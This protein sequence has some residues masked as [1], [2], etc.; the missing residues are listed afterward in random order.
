MCKMKKEKASTLSALFSSAVNLSALSLPPEAAAVI[1]ACSPALQ[2]SMEIALSN[3]GASRM[4]DREKQ[5]VESTIRYA[6]S[7]ADRN[8][9]TGWSIK[10]KELEG[11]EVEAFIEIVYRAAAEDAQEMKEKAYASLIGNFAFQDRFDMGALSNLAIILDD[12]SLDELRLIAALHGQDA[13]N[14]E[15]VYNAL[16]NNDDLVAGE[17]VNHFQSLRNRGFTVRS[18]PFALNHTIGNIKL[19]AYGERFCE[20]ANL[21]ELDPEE[22]SRLKARLN[23]YLQDVTQP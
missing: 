14:Y 22:S 5:R 21:N 18:R 8:V 1:S 12:L 16:L 15:P 2:R 6:I 7:I 3:M 23:M 4:T 20:L 13:T 17:L 9:K 19:S 10:Q 11:L